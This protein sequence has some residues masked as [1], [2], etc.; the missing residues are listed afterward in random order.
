[1]LFELVDAALHG[2][3]QPVEG[4]VE[5]GRTPAFG[6]LRFAV[7]VLVGLARDAHPDPAT[8]RV[9]AV[10]LAGVRLVRPDPIRTGPRPAH[11]NPAH[12]DP[13]QDRDELRTVTPLTG[14]N[15]Y[16]KGLAAVA[17]DRFGYADWTYLPPRTEHLVT[18]QVRPLAE[19]TLK[20]ADHLAQV[21]A[22]FTDE[23]ATAP[24][25]GLI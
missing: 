1:M 21:Q 20:P 4:R 15:H 6:P 25:P 18:T 10:A 14:G 24:V 2:M 9:A 22:V 8:A 13:F 16:C 17:A 11:T 19:G 23:V 12:P 3:T 5:G 7:S